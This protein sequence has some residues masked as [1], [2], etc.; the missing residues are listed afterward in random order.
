MAK[1]MIV[2]GTKL[3]LEKGISKL[4]FQK[5]HLLRGMITKK[6]NLQGQISVGKQISIQ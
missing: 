3:V 5:M 1:L 2:L 4:K 6:Q